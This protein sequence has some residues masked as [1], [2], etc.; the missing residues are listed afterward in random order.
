MREYRKRH[1][2]GGVPSH[3]GHGQYTTYTNYACRCEKC[4][5]ANAAYWRDYRAR[6]AGA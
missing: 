1:R 5:A 2:L 3:V 4:R 6:K